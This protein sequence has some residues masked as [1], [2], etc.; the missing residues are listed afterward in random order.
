MSPVFCCC[1]FFFVLL[2]FGVFFNFSFKYILYVSISYSGLMALDAAT[3]SVR[4]RDFVLRF[5]TLPVLDEAGNLW[6]TDG[7]S[8]MHYDVNGKPLAQINLEPRMRPLFG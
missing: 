3:G 8:L 5:P 4:W 1:C 6:G 2:F 7:S